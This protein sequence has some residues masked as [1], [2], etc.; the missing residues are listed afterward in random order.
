[1]AVLMLEDVKALAGHRGDHVVSLYLPTSRHGLDVKEGPIHLKNRLAE[2]EKI[3]AERGVSAEEIEQRLSALRERVSERSYW[4]AHSDGLALFI[5]RDFLREFRI[6]C[7][8]EEM[9]VA[10]TT[11]HVTPLIPLVEDGSE[12]HVV[13]VSQHK[14]RLFSG[15][16]YGISEV[17]LPRAPE[18]VD[19]M[20]YDRDP[21][22][23]IQTHTLAGGSGGHAVA[24]H[25]QGGTERPREEHVLHYLRAVDAEVA[26][27]LHGSRSPLLFA[28]VGSVFPLY[29]RANTYPELSNEFIPG[30]T[31][32]A[33]PEL[34]HDEAWL[35]IK[36]EM[37]R[38][39][40]DA[41]NLVQSSI[42]ANRGATA[43]ASIIRAA[44]EGR[45]DTL[46]LA[47]G[48]HEWGRHHE[49][50]G[51]V[52]ALPQRTPD[53]EDLLNVAAVHTL[54]RAGR[55]FMLEQDQ[56]PAGTAAAAGF[57]Y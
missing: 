4:Q 27:V 7:A 48:R 38:A 22:Q 45:V 23:Q 36:S 28:G 40:L 6:P 19:E 53:S 12:F 33:T 2:A 30:A 43:T 56:M 16:R 18:A 42:A 14:A 54:T 13:A 50:S 26:R 11:C 31:D 1:M 5:A 34:L 57:R 41:V 47:R 29:Q 44:S 24:F 8:F 25:G 17:E 10:A 15:N 20:F 39:A 21:H 51:Q 3:L 49:E 37:E 52:Q 55:V 9:T 32:T 46:L 35:L